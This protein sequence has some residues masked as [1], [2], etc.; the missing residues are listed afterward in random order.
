MQKA[1]AAATDPYYI[2]SNGTPTINNNTATTYNI[3]VADATLGTGNYIV[4]TAPPYVI[5]NIKIHDNN[6]SYY[7]WAIWGSLTNNFIEQDVEIYNNNIDYCNCGIS[8]WT[9]SDTTVGH[10]Q[11]ALRHN[12]HHNTITHHN[13][14]SPAT[15]PIGEQF[16]NYAL[17]T[18]YYWT[19]HEGIS[20]Q[21]FKDCTIADNYIS[22]TFPQEQ[23]D[24]DY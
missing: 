23:N 12:Y 5:K 20:F 15:G 19:D 11:Y 10:T 18:S 24:S 16:W 4:C 1:N 7:M 2:V 3:N 21:D 9:N 17:L 6:I 13:S 14:I 22:I 8:T